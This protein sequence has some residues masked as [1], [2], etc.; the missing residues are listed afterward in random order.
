MIQKGE[1][2]STVICFYR[3]LQVNSYKYRATMYHIRTMRKI[4]PDGEEK[5]LKDSVIPVRSEPVKHSRIR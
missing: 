5:Q 3:L 1:K 4:E 2:F